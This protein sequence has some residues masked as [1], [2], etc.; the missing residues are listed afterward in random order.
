[1]LDVDIARVCHEANRALQRLHGD[2]GIPVAPPWDDFPPAE[3]AGVV[4]GVAAARDGASPEVL[5]ELWC[6]TKRRD[7]WR[8]GPVKD[9]EQLLHPCLV[10]YDELPPEQRAKDALFH[11]VVGALADA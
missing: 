7:G 5:H 6:R 4:E 8:Y 9:P 2:P 10:A 3:Q 1:M 11:A